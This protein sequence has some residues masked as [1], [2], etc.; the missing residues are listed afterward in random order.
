MV[1][2]SVRWLPYEAA[3]ASS[4]YVDL[5]ESELLRKDWSLL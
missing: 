5:S 2:A 3:S 1:T 4:N